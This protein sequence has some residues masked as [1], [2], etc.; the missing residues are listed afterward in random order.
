MSH[1]GFLPAVSAFQ[2]LH[3]VLQFSLE[4]FFVY[5]WKQKTN[6]IP[7]YR[8]ALFCQH[9]LVKLLYFSNMFL[10]PMV[11]FSLLYQINCWAP[12][13]VHSELIFMLVICYFYY[14]IFEIHFKVRYAR[15][16]IFF[17][18][19]YPVSLERFLWLFRFSSN[20]R[21]FF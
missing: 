17:S 3:L 19:C 11:K 4:T 14:C 9:F 15:S 13:C 8:Y 6:F 16:L 2:I 18:Y 5:G 1:L 10:V 20:F 21:F 7:L 12:F